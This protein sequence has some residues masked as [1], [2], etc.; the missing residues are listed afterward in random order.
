MGHNIYNRH[1]VV[2]ITEE[3]VSMKKT[4]FSIFT[5]LLIVSTFYLPNSDA[6]NSTRLEFDLPVGARARINVSY[7]LMKAKYKIPFS[8]YVLAVD[9][10]TFSPDG[11]T[12]ASTSQRAPIHLWDATTGNY[13]QTLPEQTANV[14]SLRYARLWGVKKPLS[15]KPY[16]TNLAFS[17]TTD[18]FANG[19]EDK[20]IRVWNTEKRTLSQLVGHTGYV[21]S[22]TFSPDGKTLVSGSVDKT[23][24]LWD[25]T[26][27]KHKK[28]L[29]GHTDY[30]G[31]VA[32]SPD[33]KT[34]A[35]GSGDGTIRLWD[36]VTSKHIKILTGHIGGIYNILFSP[37]SA[38]LVSV[39]LD[40]TVRV[41]DT[42]TSMQKNM[43]TG[44]SGTA[45][46]VGFS[47]DGRI[48]ACDNDYSR[49]R[50][51]DVV[52]GQRVQTLL[53]EKNSIYSLAFSP[54]GLTLA[55]GDSK[56]KVL[57][58]D[59]TSIVNHPTESKTSHIQ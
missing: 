46:A 22:V 9:S 12:L 58:W 1:K 56:G 54:D 21:C 40:G 43:L 41:W 37:D 23:I 48:F 30:I 8:E 2:S 6:Q 27:G 19:G 52:T 44:R 14:L 20:T 39:G 51:W 4:L 17:P 38:T 18:K 59:L 42:T 28:T 34:L 29:T 33:G 16:G 49:I 15:N 32:F 13:K 3:V 25:A 45:W 10:L 7:N 11:K 36:A 47:P 5:L 31:S 57:L 26:T 53:S 50:I 55:S 35:S 24:R